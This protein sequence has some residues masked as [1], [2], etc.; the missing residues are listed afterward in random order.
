MIEN[1]IADHVSPFVPVT[2]ATVLHH[3]RCQLR[4]SISSS[5]FTRSAEVEIDDPA[6]VASIERHLTE[7]FGEQVEVMDARFV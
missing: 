3:G 1:A 6:T 5:R 4:C 2:P 7:V